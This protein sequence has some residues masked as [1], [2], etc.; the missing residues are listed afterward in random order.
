[1]TIQHGIAAWWQREFIH[2]SE[3][4]S[5]AHDANERLCA[6]LTRLRAIAEAAR[7]WAST[8]RPGTGDPFYGGTW[9]GSE[10][11]L[12]RRAECDALAAVV[13]GEQG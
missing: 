4:L 7:A 5:Q 6:E 13:R 1:M 2:T 3:M 12:A 10:P 9:T 11:A 8:Y